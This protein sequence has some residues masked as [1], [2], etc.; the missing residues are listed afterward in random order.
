MRKDCPTLKPP[1]SGMSRTAS[2]RPPAS[3]TFNMTVQ[4]AVRN[5]DVIAGEFDVIL[6]MD[7]L[8]NNGAQIDCERKRRE[9]MHTHSRS[10]KRTLDKAE[11][12]VVVVRREV[13]EEEKK[14]EEEEKVEEPVLVVIGPVRGLF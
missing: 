10:R 5:T 7:W 2:N 6:G 14:V 13:F 1:A 11:E 3:R 12:E 8:S 9:C 4:D